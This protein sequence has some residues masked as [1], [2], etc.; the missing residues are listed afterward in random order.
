[1]KKKTGIDFLDELG[2]APYFKKPKVKKQKTIGWY[3]GKNGDVKLVYAPFVIG[4]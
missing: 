3:Y 2:I 1:M 4:K